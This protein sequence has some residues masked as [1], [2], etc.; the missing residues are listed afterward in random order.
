MDDTLNK[1]LGAYLRACIR[2]MLGIIILIILTF[3]AWLVAEELT[4][5]KNNL[6]EHRY[7]RQEK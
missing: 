4:L 2:G 3:L 5:T 6:I 7:Y 1:T